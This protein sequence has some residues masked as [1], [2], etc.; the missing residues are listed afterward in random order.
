MVVATVDPAAGIGDATE[1][2]R[3]VG[4]A[5]FG[6]QHRIE[7]RLDRIDSRLD[8]IDSRLDG[9]DSRLDRMDSRFDGIDS[10]F[11]RMELANEKRF[12]RMDAQFEVLIALIKKDETKG[13]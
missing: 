3:Q 8:G 13:P 5:I 4:D 10:R 11:D 12:N 2:W 1:L 7:S 9:I 6:G